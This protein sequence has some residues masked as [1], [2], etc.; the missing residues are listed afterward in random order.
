MKRYGKMLC[1]RLPSLLLSTAAGSVVL[2]ASAQ[3]AE[4]QTAARVRLNIPAQ[5]LAP[6]LS[7]FARQSRQQLL[8]SPELAAGKSS[9]AAVGSYTPDEGLR[10]LLKGSGLSFQTASSGAFLISDPSSEAAG[11]RAGESEAGSAAADDVSANREE[12]DHAIIVT[13]T[14]IAGRSPAG[15]PVVSMDRTDFERV[16][17][18][19]VEDVIAKV[20]QAFASSQR[21]QFSLTGLTPQA[22]F[23]PSAGSAIN[24]RG[25]GVGTT[26][27]L[28][29]GRRL[30]RGGLQNVM[31][32]SLIPL[33]AI[34]RTEILLDGASAVYGSDAIGGVVNLIM[35][36]DF[37]GGESRV[38]AGIS[39]RGDAATYD[40]SQALGVSGSRGYLF[41]AYGF[42]HQ[43]TYLA[44]DR[45]TTRGIGYRYELQPETTT[46]SVHL[47]GEYELADRLSVEGSFGYSDRRSEHVGFLPLDNYTS[48]ANYE[49]EGIGGTLGA[50]YQLSPSW[51]VELSGTHGVNEGGRVTTTPDGPYPPN[52]HEYVSTMTTVEGLVSGSLFPLLG[53]T[54]DLVLGAAH[55]GED[56]E[57]ES[58]GYGDSDR[59]HALFGELRVPLLSG[60]ESNPDY[61]RATL[62]LAA[63]YENYETWGGTF[64]PKVGLSAALIPGLRLRGTYGTSFRAPTAVERNPF[65]A[66][67]FLRNIATPSG[68]VRTALLF[69]NN[70]DLK[71][72]TATNWTLGADYRPK[73][74]P[75]LSVGLT[76]FNI[77]YKNRIEPPVIGSIFRVFENPNIGYLIDTRNELGSAFDAT[78]ASLLAIPAF[79]F[80][81]NPPPRDDGICREPTTNFN[82]IVDG[83][84]QNLSKLETSGLDFSLAYGFDAGRNRWNG[85]VN[86]TY[87]I[88]YGFKN[89]PTAAFEDFVDRPYRPLDFR[90]NGHIGWQRGPLS[91]SGAVNY[92]DAYTNDLS[93]TDMKVRAYTTLDLNAQLALGPTLFFRN[94]GRVILNVSNLLDADPPLLID[95]Y[96]AN[97]GQSLRYDPAN[98][99]PMGR[100]FKLSYVGRW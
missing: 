92:A 1:G 61:P 9:S 47:A 51:R 19:T 100:F 21:A 25:L 57:D 83:R 68:P 22:G 2:V 73:G 27:T 4:A 24:L 91:I 34:E 42:H 80:G 41:G 8:Y 63:R 32:T 13:G 11:N 26:L 16:G 28:V 45:P 40:A 98:A 43:D 20:P 81:C 86:A 23:D 49:A 96:N 3:V 37:N 77:A 85:A 44:S 82:A 35:R 66:V 94:G 74:V 95:P 5:D 33:A 10:Q 65:N 17:A 72:E 18:A 78:L 99:D 50:R 88:D 48:V 67:Y 69:G 87:V 70:P 62:S 97:L 53:R 93:T 84:L 12:A 39:S 14:R 6:A 79:A 60:F 29:N 76:Y 56:Y 15:A 7:E 59:S 52:H 54:V 31:D 64:N 38:G 58:N 55:R 89:S 30:P 90:L 46:H 75:G 71:P 36:K